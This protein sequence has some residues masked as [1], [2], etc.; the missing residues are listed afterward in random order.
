MQLYDTDWKIDSSHIIVIIP[1]K[2][3]YLGGFN[4][5]AKRFLED[6]TESRPISLT[7]PTIPSHLVS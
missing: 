6:S 7:N 3:I 4:S 1:K 5:G 2:L